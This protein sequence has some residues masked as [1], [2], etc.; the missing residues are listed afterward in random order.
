MARGSI[1]DRA[2]GKLRPLRYGDFAI[3]LRA[4]G[5]A[6]QFAAALAQEGIP[7]YAQ[8]SGGYF[9]SIEVM[10]ALNLLRVIDNR[11]QDIPLLSV[12]RA[13]G[14]GTEPFTAQELARIRMRTRESTFF[15]ALA[16]MAAA[17]QADGGR[18]MAPRRSRA[19]TGWGSAQEGAAARRRSRTNAR[20]SLS[21]VASWREDSLLLPVDALLARLYEETGLYAQM[22]ALSGGA[23]RQANLDALLERA[24]RVRAGGRSAA[25]PPFCA[26]WTA[27]VRTARTWARRSRSGADV[28]RLLTIHRSKGLEFP[29]C[30]SAGWGGASTWTRSASGC[31]CTGRR[32]R[33]QMARGRRAVR[34]GRAPRHRAAAAARTAGRGA[35]R[36]VWWP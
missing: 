9:D 16:A 1:P 19:R 31:C 12:L 11:R 13:T 4:K 29:S 26:S 22:G 20:R 36:A 27:P 18:Q 30:S 23:Q 35:A 32:A 28:V 5:E 7:C 25:W 24:P 17:A 2:T 10:L 3:L 21:R 34:Y 6:A 15:D 8:M 33:L 14:A